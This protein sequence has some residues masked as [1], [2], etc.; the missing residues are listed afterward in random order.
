SK[1]TKESMEASVRFARKAL[2]LDPD[3]ARPWRGSPRVC[4][5]SASADG[6][7]SQDR[8]WTRESAWHGRQSPPVGDD[9]WTQIIA[10]QALA[11]FASQTPD[12]PPAALDRASL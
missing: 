7:R 8:R 2:E 10:G 5:C 11:N 1:R 4:P 6:S 3:Y 9:Q 12:G